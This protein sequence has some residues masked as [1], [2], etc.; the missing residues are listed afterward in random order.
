MMS[1]MPSD[2]AVSPPSYDPGVTKRRVAVDLDEE[3]LAALDEFGLLEG[4]DLSAIANEAIGEVVDS[5]ARRRRIDAW[6][7][8]Q[9]ELH[10]PPSREAVDRVD[11]W[12]DGL[13]LE[14]APGID[15]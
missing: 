5:A 6:L 8:E 13:D 4:R 3:L 1:G 11:R 12:L 14:P 9:D 10:G 2:A 15:S 7:D